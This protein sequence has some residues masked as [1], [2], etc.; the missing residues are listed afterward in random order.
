[1]DGWIDG[2]E[3]EENKKRVNIYLFIDVFFKK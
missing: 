2:M 3:N 1:M